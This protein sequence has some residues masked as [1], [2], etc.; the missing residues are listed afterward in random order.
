[1][2][3]NI[4][5]LVCPSCSGVVPMTAALARRLKLKQPMEC[6]ACDEGEMRFRVMLYEDAEG[7]LPAMRCFSAHIMVSRCR[8]QQKVVPVRVC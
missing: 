1:M 2:H 3:G 4:G 5:Q 7:G 8:T 6:T